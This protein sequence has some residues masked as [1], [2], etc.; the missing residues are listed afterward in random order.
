MT[1]PCDQKVKTCPS[2]SSQC[3][4][5]TQIWTIKN[6]AAACQSM[7]MNF[8]IGKTTTSCCSSDLC[9]AQDPPEP[10]PNG[11]KCYYCDGKSCSNTVSCS[12]TEDHCFKAIDKGGLTNLNGC[13]S[14]S[15]CDVA[16]S[17]TDFVSFICCEGNLCNG[18]PELHI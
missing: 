18:L 1:G 14:K 9:N 5:A 10:V 12:G 7:S 13:V 15:V 16:T 6:C 2:G 3:M 17:G 11:K 4:T 8:G